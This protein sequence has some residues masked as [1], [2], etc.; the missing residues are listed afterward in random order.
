MSKTEQERHFVS[1][2]LFW[3]LHDRLPKQGPGSDESTRRAL[4]LAAPIRESPRVLD[5]GCGPGRQT[6]VL[7]A[8]LGG[9][10][11]AL[12]LIPPFLEEV[13]ERVEAAGLSDRIEARSGS[14]LG[15]PKDAFPDGSV[16]LIWAEGSIYNVGFDAGLADWR[17]LLAPA[18]RIAVSEVAWLVE[19][20]PADVRTFWEAHYSGIRP[21]EENVRAVEAA[22][23]RLLGDLVVPENEWWDDYYTLIEARLDAVRDERDTDDWQEGVAD[24]Y[25]ELEIVRTGLGS[26]GYVFYVMERVD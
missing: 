7:A 1:I 5:M 25:E 9:Q 14:M 11:T 6:L 15:L 3:R 2:E 23:Y 8:D 10:V 19:D 22:G 4:A 13:T 17:R 18:G 24:G 26:F 16:D 12:D 20:P 21:H